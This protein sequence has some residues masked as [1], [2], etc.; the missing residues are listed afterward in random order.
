[1]YVVAMAPR[2]STARK[3]DDGNGGVP[4]ALAEALRGVQGDGDFAVGGRRATPMP[5]LI[6]EGVGTV[7]LPLLPVQAVELIARAERAPYGRGP[8]TL[9]DTAVRRSWQLGPERLAKPLGAQRAWN[10]TVRRITRRAARLLGVDGRVRAE[11]YKVLIYEAGDFFVEHRDSEKVDGMFA[12]LVVSLPAVHRGGA[13]VVQHQGLERRF[14]L[15]VEAPSHVA[16]AAFYADCVHRLEPIESGH[17]LVLVYNLLLADAGSRPRVPDHQASV[18]SAIE[19][20]A[21]WSQAPSPTKLIA[22]LDHHYTQAGLS[23]AALKGRDRA[24]ASVLVDAAAAADCVCHLAMVSIFESGAAEPVEHRRRGRWDSTDDVE[25]FEV[26]EVLERRQSLEHWSAPQGAPTLRSPLPFTYDE[27]SPPGAIDDETSDEVHFMEATG[28]EGGSYERTYRRASIVLWPRAH[29]LTVLTV[30]EPST[31]LPRLRA[32]I[33]ARSSDASVFARALVAA[34]T[35]SE[36][37][38]LV[39]AIPLLAQ[40]DDGAML[41]ALMTADASSERSLA[42]LGTSIATALATCG[43]RRAGWLDR[44]VALRV[45]PGAGRWGARD[46]DDLARF[47]STLLAAAPDE[48]RHLA[49]IA[50][51]T[52]HPAGWARGP[53]PSAGPLAEL[54]WT[55]V[56]AAP[57]LAAALRDRVL[58]AGGDD[59]ARVALALALGPTRDTPLAGITEAAVAQLQARVSAAL[60]P[61]SD[62]R[63]VAKLECRCEHCA[64]AAAFMVNPD[65][66]TWQLR[67]NENVR[68]H[69]AS[70][71]EGHDVRFET[72][73]GTSPLTL[74]CHKTLAS[75]HR[76]V[77]SMDADR[78]A[79][80]R[81]RGMLGN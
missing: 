59:A 78:A 50:I 8:D 25:A 20:L 44:A 54:M 67:A 13:L 42:P 14:E 26:I 65:L 35:L 6:V 41:E 47:L 62:W 17:R 4:A 23:F 46:R 12:T 68:K 73:R 24:V 69:V 39:Q 9:V 38:S 34:G 19:V 3:D 11:L 74:V 52:T 31:T 57:D 28:N 18:R 80:E 48:A 30:A 71:L 21:R 7:A 77:V 1:M 63:R 75:Y 81:L 72:R 27:V 64:A 58:E 66:E 29:E 5:H 76:R 51:G 16:W 10:K 15:G 70:R 61:P 36:E 56:R 55:L 33:E 40:L 43:W 60:E 49:E 32:L 53:M 22:L 37:A 79:L 45:G 2:P